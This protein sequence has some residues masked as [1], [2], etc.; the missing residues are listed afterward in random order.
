MFYL[1]LISDLIKKCNLFFLFFLDCKTVAGPRP[2][3]AISL[4]L[5][6]TAYGNGITLFCAF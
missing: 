3:K 6:F 2:G 1:T 5:P 4:K